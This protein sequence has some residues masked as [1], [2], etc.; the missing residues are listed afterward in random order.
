MTTFRMMPHRRATMASLVLACGLAQTAVGNTDSKVINQPAPAPTAAGSVVGHPGAQ[1][2]VVDPAGTVSLAELVHADGTRDTVRLFSSV[3]V[4]SADRDLLLQQLGAVSGVDPEGIKAI[5]ESFVAI[6][7]R[8]VASAV[9]LAARLG[10]MPNVEWAM[11][12]RSPGSAA[13]ARNL[14]SLRAIQRRML[15]QARQAR[16]EAATAP[17]ISLLGDSSPRGGLD[18][19]VSTQWHLLNGANPGRDNNVLAVFDDGVTGAGVT[20]SLSSIER[21]RFDYQHRDLVD[22]FNESLSDT[23]NAFAAADELDTVYAGLIAATAGN[24]FDGQGVAPG[25]QIAALIRGSLLLEAAAYFEKSIG[26]RYHPLRLSTSPF[27]PYDFS[28]PDDSYYGGA[29]EVVTQSLL[30]SISLGR[31]RNGTVQVFSTGSGSTFPLPPAY[32]GNGWFDLLNGNVVAVSVTNGYTTGPN[33]YGAQIHYYPPAAHRNTLVF[34]TVAEDGQAD[35]FGTLGT[36]VFASV[37]GATTQSQTGFS[38]ARLTPSTLPGDAFGTRPE[39]LMNLLEFGGNNA[40]GGAIATGIIALMLEVNPSLSLR[41]IQHILFQSARVD[42]L[43]FDPTQEYFR[44]FRLGAY[45]FGFATPS[46][47]SVNAANVRHSD[48]FG[49]GVIDA[50]VAVDLA[51]NWERVTRLTVLD[52]GRVPYEGGEIEDA[53]YVETSDTSSVAVSGV[54]LI[55][56]LCIRNNIQIESIEVEVTIQGAGSNDLLIYLQSPYESYSNLQYPT[57]YN[58][59]GTT[60]DDDPSDDDVDTGFAGVNVNGQNYALYRHILPT[61]KHWGELSGGRW[62]LIIQDRSPDAAL[63]EGTEPSDGDPGEDHVTTFGPLM[64]PGNP[65]QEAKILTEY[66]IRIFGTDTGEPF[67]SGCNPFETVCPGDLNADGIIN[68][69]DLQLFFEWYLNGDLRADV[70]GDG[71]LNFAD[72]IAYRSI[73]IPGFCNGSGLP[74][75]RPLGPTNPGPDNPIVRPI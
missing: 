23:P 48:Q 46:H 19:Q 62:Q 57:S 3:I 35:I 40:S 53:E 75:G 68:T 47:W 20:L 73:W 71:E 26:L 64:V 18:P 16:R 15:D 44:I 21:L 60:N 66:R 43:D 30:N 31:G 52:T 49:F 11:V 54:P 58:T 7:A 2:R 55:V 13:T 34:Q 37:Y 39:D 69:A 14:E 22:R 65:V 32:G 56:P 42:G 4:K 72:V 38:T 50:E 27:E 70:N 41:D 67:Y 28:F 5:G 59:V 61:Y 36:G 8:D 24:G 25:V 29:A 12:D 1:M 33:Y 6:S 10:N 51:R 9:A 17:G 74:G 45:L 63:T